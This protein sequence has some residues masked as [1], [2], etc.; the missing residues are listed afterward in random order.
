MMN[1]QHVGI[2]AITSFHSDDPIHHMAHAGLM[3]GPGAG[4][5]NQQDVMSQF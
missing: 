3:T 1:V 4:A 5:A 2:G